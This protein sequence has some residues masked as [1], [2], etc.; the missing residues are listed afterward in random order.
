MEQ[1]EGRKEQGRFNGGI[2]CS[3]FHWLYEVKLLSEM[4]QARVAQCSKVSPLDGTKGFQPHPLL[5]RVC[6]QLCQVK[7][8]KVSASS[9]QEKYEQRWFFKSKAQTHLTDRTPLLL[10]FSQICRSSREIERGK[11]RVFP[12]TRT[13]IRLLN[14]VQIVLF[15]MPNAQS[16]TIF[17][18]LYRV[19]F[20]QIG[21]RSL[22]SFVYCLICS[23][24]K[25][26]LPC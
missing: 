15:D 4:R 22:S 26:F 16:N 1:V 20:T 3:T 2:V 24:Q 8:Q 12:T 6:H 10:H 19:T 14:P 13:T 7:R 5:W 21:G 11:L 9:S 18:F 17:K 23:N 25:D